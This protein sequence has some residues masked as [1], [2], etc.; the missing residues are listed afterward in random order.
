MNNLR[1]RSNVGN[2]GSSVKKKRNG[3][4]KGDRFLRT[5]QRLSKNNSSSNNS[6]SNHNV[7]DSS[8]KAKRER[9]K[10]RKF[11][12]RLKNYNHHFLLLL[13]LNSLFS[14]FLIMSIF[15]IIQFFLNSPPNIQMACWNQC[16][17]P[18][19]TFF[20]AFTT[21]STTTCLSKSNVTVFYQNKF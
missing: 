3:I 21:A 6:S 16:S 5:T 2:F 8:K 20:V 14:F 18:C 1:A 12:K 17:S 15:L 9:L 11:S 4:S 19:M 10:I 7:G 13:Y